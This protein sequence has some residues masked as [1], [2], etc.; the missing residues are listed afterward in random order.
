[1]TDAQREVVKLQ[2]EANATTDV[3]EPEAGKP[4]QSLSIAD[5]LK[6]I[7]VEANSLAESS[8]PTPL[9]FTITAEKVP[10]YSDYFGY[11]ADAGQGPRDP[12]PNGEFGSLSDNTTG[13]NV[14]DFFS[15]TPSA[16]ATQFAVILYVSGSPP[17]DVFT[18]LT[19]T[20][21]DSIE[22]TLLAASADTDLS[23]GVRSWAWPLS[24]PSDVFLD[25]ETYIIEV[26]I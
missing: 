4:R 16:G 15:F 22:Y 11:G 12:P 2:P 8:T 24:P 23:L 19:F 13:L 3:F 5:A 20:G 14:V 18:S 7:R 6:L 26:V 1:M 25:G 10:S 9:G 21:A 17:T